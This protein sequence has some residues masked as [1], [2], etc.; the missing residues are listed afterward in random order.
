MMEEVLLRGTEG[1][2]LVAGYVVGPFVVHDMRRTSMQLES[3]ARW[4]VT[5]A[6]T[7]LNA[8]FGPTKSC[9]MHAARLMRDIGVDW[10]FTS[11]DAVKLFS[12]EHLQA[13][14]IIR[15]ACAAGGEA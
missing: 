9:C 5:H 15:I 3:G 4:G 1:D 7:G 12:K 14:Q 13:I 2:E 10:S 11:K 6:A 8:A